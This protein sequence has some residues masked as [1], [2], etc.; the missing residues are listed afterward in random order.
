MYIIIPQYSVI[1]DM[2][3]L[4]KRLIPKSILIPESIFISRWH[5]LP[6]F[7]AQRLQIIE[8]YIYFS[9]TDIEIIEI[10]LIKRQCN[11]TLSIPFV[12]TQN[13]W[14]HPKRGGFGIIKGRS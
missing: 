4:K 6:V 13:L 3:L 1:I 12:D 2:N 8:K 9:L 5:A 7:P 11:R 10:E 14:P